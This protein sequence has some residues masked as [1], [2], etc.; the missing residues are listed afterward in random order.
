MDSLLIVLALAA[1]LLRL[2]TVALS[3]R[4]EG[5]L[6]RAGAVEHGAGNSRLLALSHALFYAAAMGEGW[7]RDAAFDAVSAV[8]LALYL[9]SMLAL[10]V[11]VRLLGRFWTIKLLIA[12]DH[13]LVTNRLFRLVRH[14]NYFLNLLPELVG[15]ALLFHAPLT[16]AVGLPLYLVPLAWRI[17]QEEAAMQARFASYR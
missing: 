6:R 15:L 13:V 8:G 7:A 4:N 1:V 11:V 14:P 3:K 9:A 17:R 10:A 2:V 16:L 5:R 12:R